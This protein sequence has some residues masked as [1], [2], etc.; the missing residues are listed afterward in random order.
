MTLRSDS[1]AS[2]LSQ[3][4]QSGTRHSDQSHEE[5]LMDFLK[6]SKNKNKLVLTEEQRQLE[7]LRM[8]GPSFDIRVL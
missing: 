4:P 7:E 1:P 8:E 2:S 6:G 5:K 3:G